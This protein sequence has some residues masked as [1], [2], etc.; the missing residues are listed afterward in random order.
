MQH[1]TRMIGTVDKI[2]VEMRYLTRMALT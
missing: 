2:F 1:L